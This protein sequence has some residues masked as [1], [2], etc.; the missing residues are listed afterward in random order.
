VAS[1][2]EWPS[3]EESVLV[4]ET[5]MNKNK[6]KNY[7]NLIVRLKVDKKKLKTIQNITATL[8]RMANLLKF[9]LNGLV[10]TSNGSFKVV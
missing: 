7:N 8:N 2:V 10:K 4:K 1:S 5:R 9:N 3:G 6:S